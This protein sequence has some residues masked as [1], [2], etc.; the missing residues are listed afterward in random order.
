MIP[1]NFNESWHEHVYH[2]FYSDTKINLLKEYFKNNKD[3]LVPSLINIFRPFNID[4]NNIK[5]II[6]ND[7]P[8]VNSNGL[9]FGTNDLTNKSIHNVE[10]NL[11]STIYRDNIEWKLDHTLEKWCNQGFLLLNMHLTY[12]Y[13]QYNNLHYIYR[14]F[15]LEILRIVYNR[16]A[17][18][19]IL[20]MGR[21]VNNI[22]R[23]Y[24]LINI[25]YGIS[26]GNDNFLI[27]DCLVD[28]RNLVKRLYNINI[29]Y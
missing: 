5:G 20:S 11:K 25:V 29:N 19:P 18:I 9:L 16:Q 24:N 28:Y 12:P 7:T 6:I 1:I 21:T 2:L 26:P 3:V 17:D 4:I 27:E 14:Y 13:T 10:I 22:L 8:E 23:G 15:T